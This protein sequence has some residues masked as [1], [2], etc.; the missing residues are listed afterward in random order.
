[1]QQFHG[2]FPVERIPNGEKVWQQLQISSLFLMFCKNSRKFNKWHIKERNKIQT[3]NTTILN[4]VVENN[5]TY[6][7][8]GRTQR[9]VKKKKKIIIL[10]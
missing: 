8:N 1:M 9:M 3:K 6:T 10:L 4:L 5:N 7:K 2:S